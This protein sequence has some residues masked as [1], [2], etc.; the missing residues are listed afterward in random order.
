VAAALY[1]LTPLKRASQARCH[2]LC[3]LHSPLPFSL[4]R[5]AAMAGVRYGLTCV[6]CTAGLMVAMLVVGMS[7]LVWAA[8]IAVLI[9]LYKLAPPMVLRRELV[10]SALIATLGAGYFL[11]G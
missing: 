4:A 11:I 9:L 5:G 7:N 8:I 3:A 6:G 2:E 1:A 10:V